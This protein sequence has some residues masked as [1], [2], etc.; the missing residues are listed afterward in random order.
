MLFWAMAGVGLKASG[1]AYDEASTLAPGV[2]EFAQ[3][4]RLMQSFLDVPR[5]R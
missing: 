2:P 5:A 1:L 3:G 4:F